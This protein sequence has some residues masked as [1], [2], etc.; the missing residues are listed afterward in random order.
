MVQQPMSTVTRKRR[1]I[2]I[3]GDKS[4]AVMVLSLLLER[5]GYEVLGAFTAAHALDRITANKPSLVISEL[6]LPGMSG[7]DFFSRMQ[8]D[9]RFASIPV[10]FL[11]PMSDVASERKCLGMGAAGCIAKPVQ[12]EEVYQIVQSIIE[13]RP[14]ANLRVDTQAPVLL[15][16][17]PIGCPNG[18]CDIDL[19]ENG[20]YVPVL[21]SYP[22]D[23]W[24]KIQMD[25]KDRTIMAEGA[26]MYSHAHR[27]GHHKDPG[28]GFKFVNILPED[29]KFIKSFVHDEVMKGIGSTSAEKPDSGGK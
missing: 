23:R 7:L 26:V 2:V 27:I 28:V 12:P 9:R 14:R 25:L 3:A 6:T 22:R 19:S 21:R 1:T 16:D 18:K 29:Q 5:F 10:V 24:V 8:G 15:N 20:I 17:V 13:L 11:V 4:T